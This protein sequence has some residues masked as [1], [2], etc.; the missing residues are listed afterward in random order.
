M[1]FREDLLQG[2]Q[3][4]SSHAIDATDLEVAFIAD[5]PFRWPPVR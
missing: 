4:R 2:R 3:K 5:R 1:T